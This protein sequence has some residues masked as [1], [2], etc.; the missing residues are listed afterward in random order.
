MDGGQARFFTTILFLF[1]I[2]KFGNILIAQQQQHRGK[3]GGNRSGEEII[4]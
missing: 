1:C 4:D 3:K 2:V